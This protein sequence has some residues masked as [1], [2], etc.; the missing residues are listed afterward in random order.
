[1]GLQ[2][3]EGFPS[4]AYGC[5]TQHV[6]SHRRTHHVMGSPQGSGGYRLEPPLD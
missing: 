3:K 4:R 6:A 1:M 2:P 5:G